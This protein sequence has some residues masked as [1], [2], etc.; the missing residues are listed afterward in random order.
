MLSDA[1][2]ESLLTFY[3]SPVGKRFTS[4]Q[5]ELQPMVIDAQ[6]SSWYR[7]HGVEEAT[8][9]DERVLTPQRNALLKI[10]LIQILIDDTNVPRGDVIE[11]APK[12][13]PDATWAA[14]HD[15]SELDRLYA[16]NYADIPA[17]EDFAR[18]RA[19]VKV[20]FATRA[21]VNDWSD[22][23]GGRR[24]KAAVQ[25]SLNKRMPEW[26]AAFQ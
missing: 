11:P 1:E 23:P 8:P 7:P 20:L 6:Q 2:I 13:S 26:R 17:Y 4:L 5:H 9:V 21:A 25:D 16:A 3:R 15:G 12:V 19:L 18:S 14:V 22:S 24:W 10:A